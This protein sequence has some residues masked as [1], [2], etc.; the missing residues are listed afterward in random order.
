MISI[1]PHST[2]DCG[3]YRY[4]G[5]SRRKPRASARGGCQARKYA[6]NHDLDFEEVLEEYWKVKDESDRDTHVPTRRDRLI[7][8]LSFAVIPYT[9]VSY[10]TVNRRVKKL[11]ELTDGVERDRVY[12]HMLR[13]TAATHLMWSGFRPPTLDQ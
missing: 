9:T 12:L 13:A 8:E 5:E 2:C 4:Y 11:A 7:I 3:L 10:S 1:P 6:K